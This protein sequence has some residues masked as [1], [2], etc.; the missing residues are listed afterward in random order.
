[1]RRLGKKVPGEPGFS[2]FR[3]G[4]RGTKQ[5]IRRLIKRDES[6]G[7]TM[8]EADRITESHIAINGPGSVKVLAKSNAS[9]TSFGSGS[10]VVSKASRGPL[11]KR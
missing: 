2:F 6:K 1:M 9:T 5:S 10:K 4:P 11:R 3:A 7:I 8:P